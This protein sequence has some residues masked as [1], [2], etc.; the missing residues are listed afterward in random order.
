MS[1][2]LKYS[3]YLNNQ[4]M[5]QMLQIKCLFDLNNL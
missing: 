5:L 2:L 1:F 4:N 3:D